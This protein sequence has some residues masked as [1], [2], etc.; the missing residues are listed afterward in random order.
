MS[1]VNSNKLNVSVRGTGPVIVFVHGYTT[2][3]GFWRYQ[4]EALS[5]IFKVIVFDLPGHGDSPAA[6]GMTHNIESF[7]NVLKDILDEHHIDKAVVVGLSMGGCVAQHFYFKHPDR[8][9]ALGLVGTTARSFG[10]AVGA[11]K[12]IS[13]IREVG[14]ANAAQEVIVKSF[15]NKTPAHVVEWAKEE[16][17]KTPRNVAEEAI[18]SLYAF[19]SSS[20]LNQIY[21]PTF[22]AVGEEDEISPPSESDYLHE[23]IIDSEILI[24]E[25]AAHFPQLEK[26]EEFNQ[27]FRDFLLRRVFNK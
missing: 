13:R 24:I 1:N 9:T 20:K 11:D 16:V 10:P 7:A 14:V 27:G 18:K 17:S 21:V 12:V 26:P 22:I 23:K 6:V 2:T 15:S 5:D 8:V 25:D 4:V 3:S 19:D